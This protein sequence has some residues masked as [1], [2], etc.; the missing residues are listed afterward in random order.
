MSDV[1]WYRVID[2][3][4]PLYGC[5]VRGYDA[6][7]GPYGIPKGTYLNVSGMRRVDIFVGDRPFQLMAP[8]NENLGLMVLFQQLESS[9]IQDEIVE[10]ST[11]L[12]YGEFL[13]EVEDGPRGDETEAR[14]TCVAYEELYQIALKWRDPVSSTIN[15][16]SRTVLNS[17]GDI[18]RIREA[19][20]RGDYVDDVRYM[21]ERAV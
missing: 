4:S 11:E 3:L 20:N 16:F 8:K 6:S 13:E 18:A 7:E 15:V 12:P 9:P 21:I 10:L 19:F 2:P 5:D 17:A 1:K 14:L